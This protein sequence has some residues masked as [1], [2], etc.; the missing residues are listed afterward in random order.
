MSAFGYGR[1]ENSVRLIDQVA[2][3]FK[4]DAALEL[5]H[6]GCKR[7]SGK[8][9]LLGRHL[10]RRGI[11]HLPCEADIIDPE[12][13]SFGQIK[14]RIQAFVEMLQGG[15][16]TQAKSPKRSHATWPAD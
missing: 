13:F 2:D 16:V 6:P 15:G 11:P 10:A 14:L 7:G 3:K 4:I 8:S 12:S 5:C 1:I 9:F